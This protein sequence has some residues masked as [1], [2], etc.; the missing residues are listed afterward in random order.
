MDLLD[1]REQV[2]A[3]NRQLVAA[4]LVTL[5]FG[6]AS[7]VD[8]RGRRDGHQAQ[9][10]RLR[11]AR[12]RPTWWSSRSP[13]ANVVEGSLRPSSDTPTHLVLYR[14]F[15]SIGGVVHTHSTFA[16]A[17][18]Q[19]QRSIPCLGTTHADHFRGP[20]PVT[21]QL[22]RGEI[23]GEYEAA[24]GEVIVETLDRLGLDPLQM[25]AALVASHGPFTWGRTPDDAVTNAVALEAVAAMAYRTLAL[26]PRSR[27]IDRGAADAVTSTASTARTP[28]TASARQALKNARRS[29]EGGQAP[30]AGRDPRRSS[31]ILRRPG[32]DEELVRVAAVGL[33]GSDRHWFV[34]GGIGDAVHR[35]AAGPR[36][37]DRGRN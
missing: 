15:A 4:G 26:E 6:N 1:L 28:T 8:R 31:R 23:E 17:W 29:D 14:E 7:G 20:V 24:T 37:R 16:S 9:R 19:A 3:A 32:P 27:T 25:P 21:R 22:T 33:C 11:Q 5:S 12:P 2:C 35:A 10:R 36:P 34:E 18:A 30:C 13:A